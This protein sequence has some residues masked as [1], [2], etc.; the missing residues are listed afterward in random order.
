M[1]PIAD[2]ADVGDQTWPATAEA[3]MRSRFEAFRAGDEHWLV[4]SWHHTAR[5]SS[6]DLSDNPR[7]RALQIVDVVGGVHDDDTGVVEFR[8]VAR[9]ADGERHVQQERS[10]FRKVEGR[11]LYVDAATGPLV[12]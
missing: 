9:S 12:R 2:N 10:T 7:W 4:E 5:P 3:L 8:A 11:W 1:T 6:I